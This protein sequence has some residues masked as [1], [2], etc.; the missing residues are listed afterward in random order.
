MIRH[1]TV[2]FPTHDSLR[3]RELWLS[4]ESNLELI[5]TQDMLRDA[6]DEWA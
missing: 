2:P 6:W 1:G 5:G 3:N 4:G